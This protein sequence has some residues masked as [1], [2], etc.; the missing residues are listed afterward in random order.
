[1]PNPKT[2]HPGLLATLYAKLAHRPAQR[3]PRLTLRPEEK[4][5]T[6]STQ[7]DTTFVRAQGGLRVDIPDI[8][9]SV[10]VTNLIE[11]TE[12][13]ITT[14]LG[15]RSHLLRFV[16]GG[17]LRFAY[18]RLGQLI[19]LRSRGLSANIAPGNVVTYAMDSEQSQDEDAS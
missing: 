6:I 18:N 9:T 7:G 5:A 13:Q 4:P 17:E 10:G 3:T 8:I 19:E 1:M 12:H 11:V 16:N 15:S 14:I 2:L